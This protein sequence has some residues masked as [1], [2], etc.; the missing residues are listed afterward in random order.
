[1]PPTLLTPFV[2]LAALLLT[3][4]WVYQDAG[5]HVADGEPVVLRAGAVRVE[6]PAAWAALCLVLWVFF[7]PLYLRARQRTL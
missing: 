7:F 4:A 3:V 2:L 5:H 6:T 1:M